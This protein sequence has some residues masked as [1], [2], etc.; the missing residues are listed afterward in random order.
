MDGTVVILSTE[1]RAGRVINDKAQN[2]TASR[3]KAL[4]AKT[5]CFA[6]S[7]LDAA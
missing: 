2:C 6:S 7:E 5:C 1:E 3:A 4:V